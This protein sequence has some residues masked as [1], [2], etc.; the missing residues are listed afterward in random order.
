MRSC[1]LKIVLLWI[2]AAQ[3][4]GA[5]GAAGAEQKR[6]VATHTVAEREPQHA[7]TLPAL[8]R[9]A[10]ENNPTLAKAAARTQAARGRH[11]QAG[12][13]PNPVAG[14]HATEIG[15][16]GTSGQQGGFVSQRIITAGKL[17]LDQKITGKGIDAAHFQFHAQ[18]LRVLSDLRI[19][20]YEALAAQAR[21]DLT[22]ELARI[23]DAQVT[24]NEKLLK[25]R[26]GTDDVLLQAEIR[27]D[28][29][30][31][32]FDNAQNKLAEA[33]RRLAAVVGTPWMT[34][35]PLSGELSGELPEINWDSCYEEILAC[36]PELNATR[37]RLERAAVVMERARRE[38]IPNVDLSV[39]VRRN[40]ISGSDNANVQ[41]GIPIPVFDRNQGNISAA[42]AEWIAATKDVER[43]ELDL[44]DRLAVAYRKYANARQQAERYG[45]RIVPRAKESLKLVT[46][47]YDNG[48][49]DYLRVLSAQETYVQVKLSYLTALQEL[50]TSSALI[51][52]QLLTGS[53][54]ARK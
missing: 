40:N 50:R 17:T 20:F 29:S 42:E 3:A 47:A 52:G 31:I 10:L 34:V 44:Q 53:L 14:Y 26:I 37:A 22:K 51:D 30:R 28:E 8:E 41:I 5:G 2:G 24:A 9:L 27:A 33:W 21:V 12:L 7:L 38:P 18:E 43:I 23:G 32:R 48:Q 39:S 11:V 4:A 15:N 45:Y 1:H 49:V 46:N 36:N 35:G 19:R 13:Y 54:G 25:G 16:R 6:W